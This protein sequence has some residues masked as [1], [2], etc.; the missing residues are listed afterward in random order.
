[1][2]LLLGIHAQVAEYAVQALLTAVFVFS[3]KWC[4]Q[5]DLNYLPIPPSTPRL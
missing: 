3:G 1:M 2:G 5:T 4:V